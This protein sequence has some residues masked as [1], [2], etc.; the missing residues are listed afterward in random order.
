[1]KETFTSLNTWLRN[2]EKQKLPDYDKL[3]EVKLYMEQVVDYVEASI[4]PFKLDN[5]PVLTSFM[6]NNYV[7]SGI[8]RA[9]KD[10]K[11]TKIQ[12]S[13][14]IALCMLKS[15]TSLENLD[16]LLDEKSSNFKNDI[17]YDFFKKV[18][19]ETMINVLHKTKTRFDTIGKRASSDR[20][21]AKHD[22]E[23]LKKVEMSQRN[24]IIYS[25]FRLLV[26]AQIN[27]LVAEKILNEVRIDDSK[28]LSGNKVKKEK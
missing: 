27:K 8:I 4:K 23:L 1:M 5:K 21:N 26:E 3:P 19:E 22:P 10:R 6:V 7:K 15:I 12:V 14:L 13:H 11:Y 2:L 25:A 17:T 20:N 28:R 24:Q 18:E 9:P 16:L